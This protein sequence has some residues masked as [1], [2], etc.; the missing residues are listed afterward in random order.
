LESE[1]DQRGGS[2][3]ISPS[4]SLKLPVYGIFQS[5]ETYEVLLFKRGPVGY[6]TGL[7]VKSTY[8]LY[9]VGTKLTNF[10]GMA[11]NW[12]FTEISEAEATAIIL[13]IPNL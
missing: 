11:L 5:E 8:N 12:E 13:S 10:S 3:A 1:G 7:V 6:H 2:S 4:A 9:P